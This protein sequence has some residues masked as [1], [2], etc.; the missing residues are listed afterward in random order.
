MR[1]QHT[2]LIVLVCFEALTGVI[3]V[4]RERKPRTP[5]EAALALVEWALIAWLAVSG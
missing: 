3:T 1:W 4:G 2:A 5:V